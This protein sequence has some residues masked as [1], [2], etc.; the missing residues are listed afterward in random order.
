MDV[1][2]SPAVQIVLLVFYWVP[3][4]VGAYFVDHYDPERARR[5]WRKLVHPT[6]HIRL[7][8]PAATG[9]A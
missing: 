6:R 4:A 7:D 1:F 9:A 3:F 5:A 2:S 8:R